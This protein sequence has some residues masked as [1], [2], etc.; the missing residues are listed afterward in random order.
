MRGEVLRDTSSPIYPPGAYQAPSPRMGAE[1]PHLILDNGVI[2]AV[3]LIALR[4][5][6]L[7]LWDTEPGSASTPLPQ[8]PQPCPSIITV[9]KL[10]SES[11]A[12]DLASLSRVFMSRRYLVLHSVMKMVRAEEEQRVAGYRQPRR[13]RHPKD[14][15]H[16]G[17]GSCTRR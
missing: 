14:P 5:V 17:R 8:R 9:S 2:E 1:P 10:S 3:H 12:R 7:H 15:T 13:A 16:S 11:T 4:I 6:V